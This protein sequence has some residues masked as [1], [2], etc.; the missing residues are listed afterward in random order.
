MNKQRQREELASR[1]KSIIDRAELEGRPRTAEE[2]VEVAELTKRLS[3]LRAEADVQ[4]RI[5]D[6]GVQIGVA[7]Q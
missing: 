4:R 1:A 5:H 2:N 6:V 3:D 7:T